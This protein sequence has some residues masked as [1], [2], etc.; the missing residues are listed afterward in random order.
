M[1]GFMKKILKNAQKKKKQN[2]SVVHVFDKLHF[3]PC[4]SW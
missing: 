3:L 1:I 4:I 2:A